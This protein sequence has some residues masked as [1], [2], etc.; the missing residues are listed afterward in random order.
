MLETLALLFL[1]LATVTAAICV[2]YNYQLSYW[3]RRGIPGPKGELFWGNLKEVIGRKKVNV[4]QIR[5]W[6]KQFPRYY[7]IKKGFYNNLVI[8]DPDLA[9]E[10]FVKKFDH[11]HGHELH[12][13]EEDP[14]KDPKMV[15]LILARGLRW[16]RLRTISNPIFS[17]ANLKKIMPTM[18]D[19]IEHLMEYFKTVENKPINIHPIFQE[20]TMD[21]ISRIALGQ[22]GSNLFKNPYIDYA[23]SI[24][25]NSTDKFNNNLAQIIPSLK[26]LIRWLTF[27]LRIDSNDAHTLHINLFKEVMKRKSERET[28]KEN[29]TDSNDKKLVDFIDLFLDA[30]V[31]EQKHSDTMGVLDKRNLKISKELSVTEIVGQCFIFLLAGYDTTAN[32]LSFVCYELIK[33]PESLQKLVEEIDDHL[34]DSDPE[35]LSYEKINEL[36]Y[37]DSV[38]KESLRLHPIAASAVTRLCMETTEI[39][40]KEKIQ[41]EKGTN[42]T[43]D[44][45]TINYSEKL[46]G[47]E[48]EKFNPDRWLNMES[49]NIRHRHPASFLTFG[50]GPRMCLGMRLALMEEKMILIKLLKHFSLQKCPETEEELTVR[51]GGIFSPDSVTLK[52]VPRN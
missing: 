27:W 46:W 28:M 41:I 1:T 35:D 37:L 38:I 11:F 43:I 39:G 6:S 20:V 8:S 40:E 31:P 15:L 29:K 49:E 12:P 26:P 14:D 3:S 36:K 25:G 16:K 50:G 34:F 21:I 42:I 48:P 45:L 23:K 19:S 13:M 2:Y 51:G 24:I 47:P 5:D 7:G 10:I 32:S 18:Y 4:F 17:L 44:V 9:H 22:N 33:N 30:E 52:L